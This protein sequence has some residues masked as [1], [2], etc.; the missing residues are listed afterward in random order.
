[1]R[2]NS[3]LINYDLNQLTTHYKS[4]IKRNKTINNIPKNNNIENKDINNRNLFN[5]NKINE[6]SK[7]NAFNHT[8]S[9]S[10]RNTF[11]YN[12]NNVP[13]K[14][15][16][17]KTS[18]AKAFFDGK[19]K[20]QQKPSNRNSKPIGLNKKNRQ[21]SVKNNEEGKAEKYF[22]QLIC[23]NCYNNK[24]ATKNLKEQPLER[25]DLLNKTFNKVN[26]FYFQD[27]MNAQHKDNINNK[28]KELERLQKQVLDKLAKYQID[29]PTNKEQLQKKNEYSINPLN[30][31]EKE[32]P[33]LIKTQQAYDQKENFIKN[34]KDLYEIDRPRKAI[35]DYYNKCLYQVPVLEEEYHV[36]PEYKKEVNRELKKQMEENKN[37][38]KKKKDEELND[39]K[40]ANQ[41]MNDYNEFINKKNREDK[42]RLYEDYCKKNQDL[43]NY[44]KMKE[45]EEKQKGKKYE[46]E[47]KKKMKKEDEEM[48]E[49]KR[50]KKLNDINKMQNFLD[51]FENKKKDKKKEEQEE[52]DK[53]NNYAKEYNN[54]CKHGL[55]I[56]RCAICNKVFPKEQL[57]KYYQPSTN[58]SATSS[59]RS[60]FVK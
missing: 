39:E 30:S 27:K 46:E 59:K 41:K 36:D 1:M 6:N 33:R 55:D 7:Y 52:K 8:N 47:F 40:I 43:D 26:P 51:E 48:R 19:I 10:P 57:I 5:N 13:N 4:P 22:Y 12:K 53:W 44:R 18:S 3:N 45:D 20:E 49:K 15:K 35:N 42:K 9:L 2:N 14:K 50:Q 21:S 24:L 31:Y 54:K 34:N 25:K 11:V 60:S 28:I 16:F 17:N 58:A 37:N 23:K 29:N 56:Y 32:D 38:K